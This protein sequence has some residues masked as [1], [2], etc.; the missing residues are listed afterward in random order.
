[1]HLSKENLQNILVENILV[2]VKSFEMAYV[3][4]IVYCGDLMK[5]DYPRWKPLIVCHLK[6]STPGS[7]F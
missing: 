2:V 3:T 6:R 7:I 4:F 5:S 1:M